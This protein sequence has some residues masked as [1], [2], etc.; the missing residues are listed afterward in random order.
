M[1]AAARAIKYALS[2]TDAPKLIL[3]SCDPG[4]LWSVNRNDY[5][6]VSNLSDKPG[7]ATGRPGRANFW[8]CRSRTLLPSGDPRIEVEAKSFRVFRVVGR[9]SKFLDVLG[10]SHLRSLVDGAGRAEIGILAGRNTTFILRA[11]PKEVFVDGRPCPVKQE[12][13]DGY[14]HV[15]LQQCPP[16]ERA[17]SLRW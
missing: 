1:S 14:C 11:S 4:I 7:C 15:T 17:I 10:A 16:G 8:D 6:V 12:L 9:R 2:E 13:V 3:D 5:V